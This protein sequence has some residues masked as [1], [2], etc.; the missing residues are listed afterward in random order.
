MLPI[1][2]LATFDESVGGVIVNRFEVFR[3]DPVSQNAIVG[4]QLTGHVA[5]QI[6]DEFGVLVGVFRNVFFVAALESTPKLARSGRFRD[7]DLFFQRHFRAQFTGN[8]NLRALIVRAVLADFLAAGAQAGNGSGN[9]LLDGRNAVLAF[10]LVANF[11]IHDALESG[12]RA[13]LRNEEGTADFNIAVLGVQQ[14]EHLRDQRLHHGRA[15]R[16]KVFGEQRHE[17]GHMRPLLRSGQAD[18]HRHRGYGGLRTIDALYGNRDGDAADADAIN[19]DTSRV[20]RALYVGQS[21]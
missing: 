5:N 1:E 7:A 16:L 4:V 20:G 11:I 3:I 13:A 19:G 9:F 18:I 17:A 6:L 14:G 15:Q 21:R 12:N 10:G 2:L 8:A